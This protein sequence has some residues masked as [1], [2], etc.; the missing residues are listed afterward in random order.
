MMTAYL[1]ICSGKRITIS[2]KFYKVF[3]GSSKKDATYLRFLEKYAS[4]RGYYL[5][6]FDNDAADF[7]DKVADSLNVLKLELNYQ[8]IKVKCLVRYI[9]QFGNTPDMPPIS[10]NALK[11]IELFKGKSYYLNQI[12][13]IQRAEAKQRNKPKAD[14]DRPQG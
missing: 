4:K 11:V 1:M 13:V 3:V 14:S 9:N 8:V 2:S 5:Q 10:R 12:K 7:F 6:K